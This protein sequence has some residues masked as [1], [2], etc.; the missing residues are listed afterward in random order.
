MALVAAGSGGAY[1]VA[2]SLPANSVGTTQIING[3]VTGPKIAGGAVTG[4]QVKDG[5]LYAGD[6][7]AGQLLTYRGGWASTTTYLA[8]NVVYY[9]GSS[10]VARTTS[11][12]VLPTNTSYWSLLAM[13]GAT[14]PMGATGATGAT[15]PLGP[16]GPQGPVGP[17][18]GDGVRFSNVT[19]ACSGATYIASLSVTPSKNSRLLAS[20]IGHWGPSAPGQS[21]F[22]NV[23]RYAEIINSSDVVL[24]RT[25][26]SQNSASYTDRTSKELGLSGLVLAPGA[27][28]YS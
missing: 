27:G 1:A 25:G 4:T 16:T 5:S 21:D 23:S 2:T 17:S 15:G 11:T 10:Y 13:H 18:Y 7:A 19:M 24:A 14:G 22:Y 3:A 8:R 9:G 12:G 6:F 28:A 26:I 20:A